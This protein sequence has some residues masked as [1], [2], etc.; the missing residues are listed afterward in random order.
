MLKQVY[1]GTLRSRIEKF[2]HLDSDHHIQ[3][4]LAVL[5]DDIAYIVGFTGLLKFP[6]R[7]EVLD[8]SDRS[9][10]VSMGFS[11]PENQGNLIFRPIGAQ[12]LFATYAS[13]FRN[14]YY[15]GVTIIFIRVAFSCR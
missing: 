11:Q 9:D 4:A 1:R 15:Y 3:M 12:G 13:T 6:P 10:G 8:L 7:D 14:G 2:T 5:L